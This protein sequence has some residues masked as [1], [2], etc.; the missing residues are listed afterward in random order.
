MGY[1]CWN[2]SWSCINCKN[3]KYNPIYEWCGNC[4]SELGHERVFLKVRHS[5]F[6]SRIVD[7]RYEGNKFTSESYVKAL[8][9]ILELEVDGEGTNGKYDY[10]ADAMNLAMRSCNFK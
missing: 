10:L 2:K 6:R 5:L 3:I 7:I 4:G 1:T 8:A 9:D